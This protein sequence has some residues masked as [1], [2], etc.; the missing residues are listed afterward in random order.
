MVLTSREGSSKTQGEAWRIRDTR[1]EPR[2]PRNGQRWSKAR[3]VGV[4][5]A[6]GSLAVCEAWEAPSKFA[7]GGTSGTRGGDT[8]RAG[9]RLALRFAGWLFV[10]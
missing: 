10:S 8:T 2:R 7:L 5:C 1:W 9:G 4:D 6:L 3:S